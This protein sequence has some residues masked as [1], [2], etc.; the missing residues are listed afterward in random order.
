MQ[1]ETYWAYF[2]DFFH[3]QDLEMLKE[4]F[5]L[6]LKIIFQY[7]Y[8]F[9]P[10]IIFIYLFM[11]PIYHQHQIIDKKLIIMKS[12]SQESTS[13]FFFREYTVW[14]RKIYAHREE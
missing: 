7:I 10:H 13:L 1:Q 9:N 4:E 6:M 3:I 8:L 5:V 12:D 2:S 11:K 14:L